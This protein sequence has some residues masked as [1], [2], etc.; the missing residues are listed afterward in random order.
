MIRPFPETVSKQGG[1]PHR[2]FGRLL[3]SR[4]QFSIASRLPPKRLEALILSREDA[5]SVVPGFKASLGLGGTKF[6]CRM[7]R[8]QFDLARFSGDD[9]PVLGYFR[10]KA[11]GSVSMIGTDSSA[12]QGQIIIPRNRMLAAVAVATSVAFACFAVGIA[13]ASTES[14]GFGSAAGFFG[15]GSVV[16]AIAATFYGAMTSAMAKSAEEL[17]IWLKQLADG[18]DIES[19]PT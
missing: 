1:R 13:K 10:P 14:I 8:G 12:I 16:L 7:S 3:P 6:H 2:F 11:R 18:S 17:L 19:L 4:I 9:P 15:G 5:N